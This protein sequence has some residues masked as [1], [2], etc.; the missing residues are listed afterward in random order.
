MYNIIEYKMINY[1]FDNFDGLMNGLFIVYYLLDFK[2]V[3]GVLPVGR[4]LLN[5]CRGVEL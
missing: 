2:C 3:E 1:D 5:C 4:Y